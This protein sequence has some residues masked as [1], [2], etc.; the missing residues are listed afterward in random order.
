MKKMYQKQFLDPNIDFFEL[1]IEISF[2]I[3]STY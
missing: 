3:K 2:P 1:K